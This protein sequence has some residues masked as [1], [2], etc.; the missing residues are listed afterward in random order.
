MYRDDN[1]A[2]ERLVV[3][4]TPPVII[5]SRPIG[6]PSQKTTLSLKPK[7]LLLQLLPGHG[8]ESRKRSMS[9]SPHFM[10]SLWT[11]PAVLCLF[12]L[13]IY[14]CSTRTAISL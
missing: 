6:S 7:T 9:I 14:T 13:K 11:L 3:M 1:R 12:S 5:P 4:N 2:T 10:W 8:Q